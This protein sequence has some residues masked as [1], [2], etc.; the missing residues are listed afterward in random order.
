M[1]PVRN[2]HDDTDYKVTYLLERIKKLNRLVGHM[3]EA[4]QHVCAASDSCDCILW[5][6]H[7]LPCMLRDIED[8]METLGFEVAED[9][10]DDDVSDMPELQRILHDRWT[11]VPTRSRVPEAS[12]SQ[13]LEGKRNLK[14]TY[15]IAIA[16]ATDTMM[17]KLKGKGRG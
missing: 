2:I 5:T 14:T 9:D 16:N 17:D 12:G 4:L 15:H 3:H 7:E 11:Q 1:K 10:E 13:E 8:E 6:D